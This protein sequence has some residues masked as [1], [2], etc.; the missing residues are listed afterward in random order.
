MQ[1]LSS[2][3]HLKEAVYCDSSKLSTFWLLYKTPKMRRTSLAEL[4]VEGSPCPIRRLT[5]YWYE[6]DAKQG[7]RFALHIVHLVKAIPLV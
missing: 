1:Q 3:V 6:A 2:K 4:R 7:I 5:H